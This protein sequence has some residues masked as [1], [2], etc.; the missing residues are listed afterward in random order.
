MMHVGFGGGDFL[1][2]VPLCSSATKAIKLLF[3]KL[4]LASGAGAYTRIDLAMGQMEAM[5][6]SKPMRCESQVHRSTIRYTP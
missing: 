1:A 5:S 4:P 6:I 3:L 2:S